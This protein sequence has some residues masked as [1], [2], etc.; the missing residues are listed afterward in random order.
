[1]QWIGSV[2]MNLTATANKVPTKCKQIERIYIESKRESLAI[3]AENLFSPICALKSHYWE[4]WRDWDFG[5][6]SKLVISEWMESWFNFEP[7]FP[8][9]YFDQSIHGLFVTWFSVDDETQQQPHKKHDRGGTFSRYV[10]C[11]FPSCFNRFVFEIINYAPSSHRL[12]ATRRSKSAIDLKR[13]PTIQLL[14][15]T[16][17]TSELGST[18]TKITTLVATR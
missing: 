10:V 11:T 6:S 7:E 1:M 9:E 2:S 16:I 8:V 12:L 5:W 13:L 15:L 18:K 17:D 14:S 3:I 4:R